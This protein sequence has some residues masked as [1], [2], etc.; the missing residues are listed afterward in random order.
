MVHAKFTI[1]DA[2]HHIE[3]WTY[4][5]PNGMPIHARFDLKRVGGESA[6]LAK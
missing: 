1:V 4:M 5:L 3:E 6:A 2:N